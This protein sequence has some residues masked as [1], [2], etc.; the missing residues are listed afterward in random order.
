MRITDWSSDVCSSDLETRTNTLKLARV[1]LRMTTPRIAQESTDLRQ[2]SC[3]SSDQGLHCRSQLVDL[4]QL[5]F[6]ELA[7]HPVFGFTNPAKQRGQR[8]RV[9]EHQIRV[10]RM[11]RSIHTKVR[12]CQLHVQQLHPL[13]D[14]V[15]QVRQLH[16]QSPHVI[17]ADISLH[18]RQAAIPT[19]PLHISDTHQTH[20]IGR[21]SC[22]ERVCQYV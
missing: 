1:I 4:R 13:E 22:R 2:R 18:T 11:H 15:R 20:K 14:R 19:N 10:M 9:C 7:L 3:E 16:A 12:P 21:A 6:L 5:R 8:L 17:L